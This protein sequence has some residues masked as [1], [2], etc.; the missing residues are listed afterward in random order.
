MDEPTRIKNRSLLE[1]PPKLNVS[2]PI[3]D[4]C[5]TSKEMDGRIHLASEDIG[6]TM[7]RKPEAAAKSDKQ[8]TLS[9]EN[10][11]R[12]PESEYRNGPLRGKS[13]KDLRGRNGGGRSNIQNRSSPQQ[14]LLGTAKRNSKRKHE[15]RYAQISLRDNNFKAR[16]TTL[17]GRAESRTLP[18][19]HASSNP[20]VVRSSTSSK[21]PGTDTEP[22]R[23]NVAIA[24]F[25][26]EGWDTLVIENMISELSQNHSK[27]IILCLQETWRYE[28]P[29]EFETRMADKYNIVHES[30][31]DPSVPRRGRPFG[32]VCMIMS[33][34]LD[35]TLHYTDARC[36]SIILKDHRALINNVYLPYDNTRI[37][38]TENT[39]KYMQAVSHL[40]TAHELAEDIHC[41]IT[42][43]D[44]NCAPTDYNDRAEILAQFLNDHRYED[45]DLFFYDDNVFTHK[46]GRIIDR[47]FMS[48]DSEIS[49]MK[50]VHVNMKFTSS[51]H[52]P[53]ISEVSF[54][55]I[56][57]QPRSDTFTTRLNWKKANELSLEAYS[58]LASKLCAASLI[59]FYSGNIDGPSLYTE[60]VNNLTT[61]AEKCIPKYKKNEC[62]RNHNIPMWRERMT[63]YQANVDFWLQSQFLQGGPNRC[64]PYIRQQLRIARAQY[65]R[66]HRALRREIRGS[67]SDN[68]TRQ[69]CH[70]T[71][72]R[73]SKAPQPSI[74]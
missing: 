10:I 71:L 52:F 58:K 43:G 29:A 30:A 13:R 41:S 21:G 39:E 12:Q 48:C 65:K 11:Y 38:S 64:H 20:T 25:N 54:Q 34:S 35:Y 17:E 51:D 4:T 49:S 40:A 60:T 53:V 24:T 46:S 61:A 27:N 15:S 6:E 45:T 3:R 26:C 47:I 33:K 19:Q 22:E 5:V 18:R 31:M 16:S 59:E 23:S 66:Q 69:N 2:C 67:I 36:Q 32:G 62:R 50:N 56:P 72:F 73:K 8:P 37:P 74:I 28:I 42:I 44:V 7:G 68:I 70:K 9:E 14:S 57:S 55:N 63:T 1:V